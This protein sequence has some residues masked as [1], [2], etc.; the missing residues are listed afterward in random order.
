MSESTLKKNIERMLSVI[1]PE[2][3]IMI[4]FELDRIADNEYY[5]NLTYVVP[6]DSPYMKGSRKEEP[7]YDWNK[8]IIFSIRDYFSTRVIV[9]STSLITESYYKQQKEREKEWHKN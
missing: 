5:I 4:D 7:R 1:K 6:D 9:N 3:V 2:G 8:E